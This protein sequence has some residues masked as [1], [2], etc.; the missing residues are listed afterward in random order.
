ME[1]EDADVC[2]ELFIDNNGTFKG[3]YFYSLFYAFA[4]CSSRNKF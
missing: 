4:E 3:D 1:L 2:W